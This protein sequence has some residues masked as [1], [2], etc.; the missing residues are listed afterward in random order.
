MVK[1]EES[2]KSL[3]DPE[4]ELDMIFN[5]VNCKGVAGKGLAKEF[6][7]RYPTGF[8]TYRQQCQSS[9]MMPDATGKLRKVPNFQPGDV[10]HFVDM[11]PQEYEQINQAETADEAVKLAERVRKHIVYFPTKNHWKRPSQLNFIVKGM[12]NVRSL[13]E[14]ED[15]QEQ[16][17]R[18]GIPALGCG[19]GGLN[20]ADVRRTIEEAL[21]GLE[22]NYTV[23]LFPPQ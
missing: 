13:L 4:L 1:Y 20:W 21:A 22:A 15:I 16:V 7:E 8:A 6:K 17:H 23:V 3:F 9:M 18:I 5:P 10:L 11:T 14:R 2:D 12:R 19:L